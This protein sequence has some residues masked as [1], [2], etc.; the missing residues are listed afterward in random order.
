MAATGATGFSILIYALL[1]E[2]RR[3]R[4][5]DSAFP[6]PFTFCLL[7]FA[8]DCLRRGRRALLAEHFAEHLDRLLHLLHRAEGDARHRL[9]ERREVAGNEHFLRAAR[10][11]E[12]LGRRAD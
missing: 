5:A 4:T 10:I 1:K 7:P 9:L 12:F 3:A 11:A 8:F 2:E 6:F